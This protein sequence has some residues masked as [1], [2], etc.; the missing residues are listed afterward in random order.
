MLACVAV[1]AL[2]AVLLVVHFQRPA[3][4]RA[5]PSRKSLTLLFVPLRTVP[6]ARRDR[7][8]E[9]RPEPLAGRPRPILS[10][11]PDRPAAPA[12][13]VASGDP[14]AIA[15]AAEIAADWGAD[16]SGTVADTRDLRAYALS[17]AGKADAQSR[18]GKPV[19]LDAVDTPFKR[20]QSK[21]AQAARGGA[22]TTT[23][24]TSLSGEPVTVV[25][26]NGRARCYM[27]VSTS[28]APSAV[29]DNRGSGRS[30]EVN[31]PKGVQ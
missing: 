16:P 8:A 29:F 24:T 31:C 4:L 7:D 25:R 17:I 14:P 18:Q 6:P 10:G 22:T 23:T 12:A 9:R 19:P 1:A 3:P 13:P 11:V 28:V 2:H 27:P 26:R 20:M 5:E 15:P 30:T 21:M